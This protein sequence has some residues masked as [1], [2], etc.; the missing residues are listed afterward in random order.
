MNE[1]RVHNFLTFYLPPLILVCIGYAFLDKDSRAFIYLLGYFVTYLA[2]RLEIHHYSNR[3]GYHRDPKFVKTLVVSE[4]VVLGFLLPTL[5][6]YSTRT[7]FVKNVLIYLILAVGSFELISREYARLSWQNCLM[8]SIGLS[9][10]IFALTHS[11]LV[12][13]TF[14]LLALWACLVVK[15]DLK[16]YV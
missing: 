13:P 5:L 10:V 16:L 14:V 3:W 15:H 12:P 2:I 8:L 4:L 1:F 11:M 6:A 9:I 7:T